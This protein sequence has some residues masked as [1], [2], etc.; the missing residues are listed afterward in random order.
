MEEEPVVYN[1]IDY[2]QEQFFEH[3]NYE[4]NREND[5]NEQPMPMEIHLLAEVIV[6][7][8]PPNN[9]VNNDNLMIASYS[10][11]NISYDLVN[12]NWVESISRRRKCRRKIV[13]FLQDR[14]VHPIPRKRH[15]N[16]NH[17]MVTRQRTKKNPWHPLHTYK[18]RKRK[19]FLH[20][21]AFN[22]LLFI[23]EY[24]IQIYANFHFTISK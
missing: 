3:N 5:P 17:I 14:T 13:D 1:D 18:L 24:V 10:G 22:Y 7:P 8:Q 4:L 19:W 23:L 11:G 15:Y 16:S 12:G 21:Y 9:Q 20:I 2:S 6:Q